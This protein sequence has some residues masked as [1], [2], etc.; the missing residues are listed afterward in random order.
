VLTNEQECEWRRQPT[1]TQVTTSTQAHTMQIL[2]YSKDTDVY[3][4]LVLDRCFNV[5]IMEHTYI[6]KE[7]R[8]CK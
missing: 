5:P 8:T 3:N 6:Q 1:D 7:A 2:L 4:K